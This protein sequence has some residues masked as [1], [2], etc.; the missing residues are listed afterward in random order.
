MIWLTELRD[1][2]GNTNKFQ[3]KAHLINKSSN[4]MKNFKEVS[5]IKSKT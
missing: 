4:I 1:I 2:K 3:E 5:E